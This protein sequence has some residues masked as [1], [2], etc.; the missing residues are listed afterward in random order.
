M[1]REVFREKLMQ[2]LDP[3]GKTG[4]DCEKEHQAVIELIR[5]IVPDKRKPDTAT[6]DCTP[7]EGGCGCRIDEFNECREEILSKLT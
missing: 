2:A 4:P 6:C 5:E 7:Y 3:H 1:D